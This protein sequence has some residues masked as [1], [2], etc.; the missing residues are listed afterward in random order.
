MCF[1][2]FESGLNSENKG[3][4]CISLVLPTLRTAHLDHKDEQRGQA[5]PL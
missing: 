4:F 5:G 2:Y 1:T 3:G